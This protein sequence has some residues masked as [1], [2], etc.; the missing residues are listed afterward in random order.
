MPP[1]YLSTGKARNTGNASILNVPFDTSHNTKCQLSPRIK[2]PITIDYNRHLGYS[3]MTTMLGCYV[4]IFKFF[5]GLFSYFAHNRLY[6]SHRLT[7]ATCEVSI[8]LAFF[9]QNSNLLT[10]LETKPKIKFYVI[11]LVGVGYFHAYGRADFLRIIL[12]FYN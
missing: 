2:E 4:Y 1:S 11:I 7:T 3:E 8:I 9:G 5:F 10:I 12:A 6:Q